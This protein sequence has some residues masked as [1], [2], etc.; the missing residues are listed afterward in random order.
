MFSSWVTKVK[1]LSLMCKNI[2]I[3]SAMRRISSYLLVVLTVMSLS[4]CGDFMSGMAAGLA[5]MG[6]GGGYYGVPA[7]NTSAGFNTFPTTTPMVAPS[8]TFTTPITYN[9]A[10]TTT[11]YSSGTSSSYSSGSASSTS[12]SGR[13]CGVCYGSG[14]CRTCNGNGTYWDSLNGNRK[15]CPNC[16]NGLCTSCGGTGKK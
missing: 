10:P 6:Q 8:N 5:G 4:S 9:T 12:S 7:V 16:S 2:N 1:R 3:N 13:S 11:S 14:K 15:K